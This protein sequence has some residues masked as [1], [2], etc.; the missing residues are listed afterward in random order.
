MA[1]VKQYD[2]RSGNT[3]VYESTSYWD[4]EKKQPRSRRKLIGRLDPETGN[5]VPTDGRG[6]RRGQTHPDNPAKRGPVPVVH[7]ERLFFGATYLFDQIGAVTGVTADLKACFPGRDALLLS[8]VWYLVMEDREPLR[9]FGKWA[10]FHRNPFGA[11]LSSAR[12][13]ELFSSVTADAA[14]RFFRLRRERGADEPVSVY[15]LS[16]FPSSSV[17]ASV[18]ASVSVHSPA[19]CRAITSEYHL[20]LSFGM[21]FCVA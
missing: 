16:V 8:V 10:A 17:S 2:K 7:T 4:K 5:V 19:P 12:L 21:R 3:Y 14:S 20:R 6:K 13:S 1:I 9:R 11:E 15:A 18:S